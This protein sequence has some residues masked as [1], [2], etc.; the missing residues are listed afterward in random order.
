[1]NTHKRRV[2]WVK[3]TDAEWT[4]LRVLS[5]KRGET[6]TALVTNAVRRDRVT[7]Q[8]FETKERTK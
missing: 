5:A 6:M 1:M 8:A 7:K 2:A 4:A 3:A